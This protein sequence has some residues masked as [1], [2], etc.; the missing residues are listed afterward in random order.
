M[1]IIFIGVYYFHG[2]VFDCFLYWKGFWS[3]SL[4]VRK[5]IVLYIPLIFFISSHLL[6]LNSLS[7]R[8]ILKVML[9]FMFSSNIIFLQY[10]VQWGLPLEES[11]HLS[12]LLFFLKSSMFGCLRIIGSDIILALWSYFIFISVCFFIVL[13]FSSSF[14]LW[15]FRLCS[16]IFCLVFAFLYAV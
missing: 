5:C 11:F 9:N 16:F 2:K 15:T 3:L 1:I 10:L 6:P 8:L 13:S 4:I 7:F 14:S 12:L